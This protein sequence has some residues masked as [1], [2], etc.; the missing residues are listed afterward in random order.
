MRSA[1]GMSNSPGPA[2]PSSS[3]PWPWLPPATPRADGVPPRDKCPARA[4]PAAPAAACCSPYPHVS[5]SAASSTCAGGVRCAIPC[6]S[7]LPYGGCSCPEGAS[8]LPPDHTTPP[9]A[10]A[11]AAARLPDRGVPHREAAG[12]PGVRAQGPV[13]RLRW[14]GC[15]GVMEGPGG[16][17]WGLARSGEGGLNSG[18][19]TLTYSRQERVAAEEGKGGQARR[20]GGKRLRAATGVP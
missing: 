3:P 4:P 5:S 12:A 9:A 15:G 7:A 8:P 2:C 1:A 10:A 19:V 13:G 20:E 17:W 6:S 16:G 14:E 11:T 18:S